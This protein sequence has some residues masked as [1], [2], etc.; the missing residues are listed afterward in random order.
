MNGISSVLPESSTDFGSAL[1]ARFSDSFILSFAISWIIVNKQILLY[2]FFSEDTYNSKLATIS[3]LKFLYS[4]HLIFPTLGAVIYIVVVP[5]FWVILLFVK[6]YTV[7]L[8]NYKLSEKNELR[9]LHR[10]QRKLRSEMLRN[11]LTS[12]DDKR[13]LERRTNSERT[14]AAAAD[15]RMN[16]IHEEIKVNQ[17]LSQSFQERLNIEKQFEDFSSKNELKEKIIEIIEIILQINDLLKALST[18]KIELKTLELQSRERATSLSVIQFQ[19]SGI[20][21]DRNR[22]KE[23]YKIDGYLYSKLSIESKKKYDMLFVGCSIGQITSLDEQRKLILID[24]FREL[25]LKTNLDI[26]GMSVQLSILGIFERYYP[27]KESETYFNHLMM[28][29]E[30]KDELLTKV[31]RFDLLP[32]GSLK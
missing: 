31:S 17:T 24:I 30:H 18:E 27:Y 6:H 13:R 3:G 11:R 14:L 1:K 2:F 12:Q 23:D 15:H 22:H 19:L 21:S 20:T 7:D 5:M 10:A 26:N 4:D 9:E 16:K 28:L 32:W 29:L 25:E 8:F